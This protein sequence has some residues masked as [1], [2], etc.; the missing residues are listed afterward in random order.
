MPRLSSS[1]GSLKA[2]CSQQ[3]SELL[4]RFNSDLVGEFS[5]ANQSGPFRLNLIK[6]PSNFTA[7]LFHQASSSDTHTDTHVGSQ[8]AS[9]SRHLPPVSQPYCHLSQPS[10]E[11]CSSSSSSSSSIRGSKPPTELS[12]CP[13]ALPQISLYIYECR[14]QER[15]GWYGGRACERACVRASALYLD[16]RSLQ[17]ILLSH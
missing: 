10:E 14:H 15:L 13:M 6:L 5:I 11:L 12:G 16:L 7:S 2:C 4:R 9:P 8:A 3:G 17:A 1:T